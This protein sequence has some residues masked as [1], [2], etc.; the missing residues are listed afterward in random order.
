MMKS[1]NNINI[2][3]QSGA[4]LITAL[5]MLVILTMLG[6]SSMTTSTMEE[7]MAANSQE[8][9]RAFQA[10]SSGLELVFSDEDAFNTTNTEA[11]DTYIKSDTTVGGDPSGSNAY[12]ATTEYSSTFIQ[13]VSAPRGSGWDSTFAFYYFDLS[14]T[15][16]TASGA[17]SSLHSGAYQVGKGT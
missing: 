3:N 10:A 8:I 4:V 15:G 16:S 9:N 13:Q 11:S 2:K 7:R 1:F 14:A 12:S 5:I 17:S 6:L